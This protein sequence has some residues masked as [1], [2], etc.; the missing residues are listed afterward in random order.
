MKTVRSPE[1]EVRGQKSRSH[2]SRDSG[3]GAGG[4]EQQEPRLRSQDSG[5]SKSSG[6]RFALDKRP[7]FILSLCRG[8]RVPMLGLAPMSGTS[9]MTPSEQKTFHAEARRR[10]DRKENKPHLFAEALRP[11]PA[12]HRRPWS[13]LAA[14][15]CSFAAFMGWDSSPGRCLAASAAGCHFHDGNQKGE[16]THKKMLKMQVAPNMLLKTKGRKTA[17][18]VLANMFMKTGGLPISPIC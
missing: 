10:K 16:A 2:E 3:F 13:H 6:P 15:G 18:P 4:W 5:F 7:C 12:G 11:P 14:R 8:Q 9:E 17:N 1:S